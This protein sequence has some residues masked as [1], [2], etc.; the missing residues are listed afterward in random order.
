MS[1][2]HKEEIARVLYDLCLDPRLSATQIRDKFLNIY[3]STITGSYE[4]SA[5]NNHI[6]DYRNGRTGLMETVEKLFKVLYTN[7][8]NNVCDDD[9]P[10][11][12]HDNYLRDMSMCKYFRDLNRE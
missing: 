5:V 3:Q 7:N 10:W 8:A 1:C 4:L 6:V 9:D 11:D 2:Q 12:R